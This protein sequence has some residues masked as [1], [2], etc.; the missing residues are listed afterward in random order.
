MLARADRDPP[1]PPA[2]V[3]PGLPLWFWLGLGAALALWVALRLGAFSLFV[4]VDGPNG[5]VR[6]PN[7][8]AGVDH[9]FHAVR[10]ETLRRALADG[11]LLRWVGHHQGGYPVEFYPLGVAWLEVAAWALALGALPMVVVHKLVVILIFLAPGVAFLLLGR[12]DGWSPGVPLVAFAAHVAIPGDWQHGGY[13][14]L[15]QW[16]LVT[17]VAAATALLFVLAWLID[18][19]E[20]GRRAA[21]VGAALAAAFA[22]STNP[23][24]L[25]ALAVVGAAVWL[26]VALDR[27]ARPSLGATTGRLLLV[28]AGS[29][30]LAAPELVALLRFSPLYAFARYQQYEGGGDFLAAA[31]GAVG[32]PIFGLGLAGAVVAWLLPR[33][34]AARAAAVGLLLYAGATLLFAA[35]PAAAALVPQLE[36]PRL[37]PFQRF[38]TLYLAACAVG[39]AV[40]RFSRWTRPR[41]RPELLFPAA[42]LAILA[43]YVAPA[44]APPPLPAVDVPTRGLYPVATTAVPE[45]AEFAAAIRAA[46]EAAPPGTSILVL[47][48]ALSWHQQLW[49]PL[50]TDRP[51][52]YDDW[53]WYWHPDHAGPAGYA[54]ARGHSYPAPEL[55]LERDYLEHHGIGAVAVTGRAAPF[56]AASPDLEV[57]RSGRYDVYAVREPTTIVTIGGANAAESGIGGQGLTAVGRA[58]GGEALVRRNWYPRW[59][60]SVDGERVAIDRTEDGYMRVALPPGQARLRLDYAVDGLDWLARG[61]AAAGAAGAVAFLAW[62]GRRATPRRR[63]PTRR[64]G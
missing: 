4:T 28:G 23:R 12:R 8:F 14:E 38:L 63:S 30:L 5:L 39:A 26:A 27:R 43:V 50:W 42:A 57:V 7:G 47:G 13:T 34:P 55:A 11:H 54:F 49:A 37:M 40:G 61:L 35:Q 45:Q 15:V 58:D 29:A 24:S 25:I 51:L 41:W 19:L 32:L 21:G 3:R 53:L 31:I 52:Y 2:P 6:L 44:G 36:A 56:A 18:F 20:S 48:S 59:R 16:G 46:D 10:A 22:V 1:P 17:N 64:G 62:P 33:R 9:P 60:A